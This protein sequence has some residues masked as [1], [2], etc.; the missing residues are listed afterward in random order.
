MTVEIRDGTTHWWFD[1]PYP[2][3]GV[4]MATRRGWGFNG[5]PTTYKTVEAEQYDA[6]VK[7]ALR[8]WEPPKHASL[9]VVIDLWVPRKDFRKIDLDKRGAMV[10]DSL[11]GPRADQW[12]DVLTIQK[13][14][15]DDPSGRVVVEVWARPDDTAR[16]RKSG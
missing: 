15:T 3:V 6:E 1:L 16:S 11:I 13:R 12:I 8:G 7:L 14:P 9:A 2:P 10:L 4:N 5:K